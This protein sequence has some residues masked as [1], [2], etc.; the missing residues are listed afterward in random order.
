MD[1]RLADAAALPLEDGSVDLAIAFMSLH[2]VDD[3]PSAV[4]EIARI[5]EPGGKLCLAIVHPINSAGTFDDKTANA[6]FVIQGSYLQP[7][8][9]SDA[10]ERDGL[11]LTF[12]SEHR[13]LECYF[14]AMEQ[15][16]FLIEALR[17]PTY[18]EETVV[19]DAGRRW[20]RLPLFLHIRAVRR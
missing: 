10:V 7:Y 12:H 1:I 5:L 17:E 2:D 18:S 19:S 13:P 9:Y 15:A 16:G 11:E 6:P 20:L 14:S 8:R 3:M 4:Q